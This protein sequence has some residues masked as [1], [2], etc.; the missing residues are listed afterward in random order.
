MQQSYILTQEN[1]KFFI[2][3]KGKEK[4]VVH[5]NHTCHDTICSA[6]DDVYDFFVIFEQVSNHN[7]IHLVSGIC[8]DTALQD[9]AEENND[10]DTIAGIFQAILN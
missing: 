8:A 2:N 3:H 4:H 7:I 5:I 6:K 10:L 9:F 1:E